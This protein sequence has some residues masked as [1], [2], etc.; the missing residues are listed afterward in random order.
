M[1]HLLEGLGIVIH[2]SIHAS[3]IKWLRENLPCVRYFAKHQGGAASAAWWKGVKTF[4]LGPQTP[5]LWISCLMVYYGSCSFVS[6]HCSFKI[7]YMLGGGLS[8]LDNL[9]F[10]RTSFSNF[11]G[12]GEKAGYTAMEGVIRASLAPF[13]GARGPRL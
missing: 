7:T 8:V 3:I 10:S 1:V 11:R 2:P 4:T 6:G 9:E 5:L 13:S 12:E